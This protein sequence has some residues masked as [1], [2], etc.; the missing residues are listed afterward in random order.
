MHH[1]LAVCLWASFLT[2]LCFNIL[3]FR[4]EIIIVLTLWF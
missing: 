1:L 4:M 2:S 3:I